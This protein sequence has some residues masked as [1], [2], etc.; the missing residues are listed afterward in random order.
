[1]NIL[2][3]YKTLSLLMLIYLLLSNSAL[4][5]AYQYSKNNQT[6]YSQAELAQILAPI[7]LYPDSLLTHILIAST[8][9]IELVQAHRWRQEN[10]QLT[11]AHAVAEAENYGW[12]PSVIALVAFPAVLT[13][14]NDDLNWTQDLGFA[15]IANEVAVLDSIQ[16]LRKQAKYADSLENLKYAKVSTINHQIII[17]P[18]YKHTVYVP[19]YDTRVVYG[20]WHWRD[21]PPVYWQHRP[22][23]SINYSYNGSNRF[24]W[25]AGINIHF[26][27]FFGAFNWHKRHVV[28][29]HHGRSR[30]YRS[31][32]RIA[33]SHGAKR[34]KHNVHH[35]HSV[36]Y[37]QSNRQHYY[38]KRVQTHHKHPDS[39]VRS[40]SVQKTSKQTLSRDG[41]VW[42]D[43][44]QKRK[45]TNHQSKKTTSK[46]KRLKVSKKKKNK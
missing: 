32:Q 23:F 1:M 39:R 41:Y 15:F 20:H 45:A 37:L 34:W 46:Q 9:P 2:N 18:R 26:N 5:H 11:P 36:S 13:R 8:Y 12:D 29:T 3:R 31:H 35:K 24:Y 4:S 38:N 40:Y 44:H 16:T 19:Y 17:E 33:N 22:H 6:E 42:K 7:A 43:N 28:I 25:D 14:L 27:Y 30:H 10:P 21:Y